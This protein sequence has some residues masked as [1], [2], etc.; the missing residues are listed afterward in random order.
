[1]ADNN[2]K[3]YWL[4]LMDDFFS[5]KRIRK[6]RASDIGDTAVV[7]YEEMMLKALKSGGYLTFDGLEENYYQELALE[8]FEDAAHC[9]SV[10]E[11]LMQCGLLE[12]DDG[13][14]YFLPEVARFTGSESAAAKKMRK[15]RQKKIEQQESNNVTNESNIVTKCYTEK[16]I[17][18][19]IETE[20]EIYSE[21]DEED[22]AA[23]A[24]I[25]LRLRDEKKYFVSDDEIK[26][27]S[28]LY[29]RVDIRQE[30]KTMTGWLE[31]N[32]DKRKEKRDM[33]R[34]INAWLTRKQENPPEAAVH[35]RGN[36]AIPEKSYTPD[37]LASYDIIAAEKKMMTSVPKLRSKKKTAPS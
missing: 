25:I 37:P 17:E 15:S 19:E 4:R 10:I 36:A 29:P 30:L 3:Y 23:G 21:T 13:I 22:A 33:P 18:K 32:P 1:M 11:T 2:P 20:K 28:E 8:L 34:F 5:D 7:I 27:W 16:E 9:K 26:K 14:N 35:N 6:L 12:T 31:A 24:A